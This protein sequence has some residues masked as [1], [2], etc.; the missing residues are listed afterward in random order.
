MFH[1]RILIVLTAL[2]ALVSMV[3]RQWSI[4]Q[5]EGIPINIFVGWMLLGVILFT[6][7][8]KRSKKEKVRQLRRTS[9]APARPPLPVQRHAPSEPHA[10]ICHERSNEDGLR[11]IAYGDHVGHFRNHPIPSW[12]E[13]EDGRRAEF[14]GTVPVIP[15]S[16]CRCVELPNQ[17]K[18]II[19]PGLVYA[20]KS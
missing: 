5:S 13:T 9:S 14:T 3:L 10:P 15:P 18:L 4:I 8:E 7:T 17:G 16:S 2:S 11:V 1:L 6:V 12:I 20:F 19:Q